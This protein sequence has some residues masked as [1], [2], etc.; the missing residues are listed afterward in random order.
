MLP[1]MILKNI[2]LSECLPKIIM[3]WRRL[4]EHVEQIEEKLLVCATS[5][6]FVIP[7][8]VVIT[9]KIFK[10]INEPSK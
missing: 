6:Q 10:M 5:V 2:W 1:D 8:E 9:K 7:C 3:S 4:I